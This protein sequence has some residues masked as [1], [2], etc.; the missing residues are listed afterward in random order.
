MYSE[1]VSNTD[2]D[3]VLNSN[4]DGFKCNSITENT[5]NLKVTF[6]NTHDDHYT[7]TLFIFAERYFSELKR[8]SIND[9]ANAI[10]D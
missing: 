6:P 9:G 3:K 7:S 5:F 10:V 8:I 2:D 1:T 4:N